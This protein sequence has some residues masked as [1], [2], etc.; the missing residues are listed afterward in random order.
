MCTMFRGKFTGIMFL[1]A[2]ATVPAAAENLFYGMGNMGI[3][4]AAAI[5]HAAA[6]PTPHR[7]VYATP[8]GLWETRG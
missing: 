7:A 5:I 2:M 3:S 6:T 1:L 8:P 4:M